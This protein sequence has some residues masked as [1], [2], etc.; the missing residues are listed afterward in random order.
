MLRYI[1]EMIPGMQR[2]GTLY[3]TSELNATFYF[4]QLLTA[5]AKAGLE[6]KTVGLISK[7]SVP[8]A[9]QELCDMDVDAIVQLEDNLT[10]ATFP[11][12][13]KVANE[14]KIP[15]FSFVNE[16]AR[17]GSVMVLS[18]D[19]LRGARSAAAVAARIMKGEK[20]INIPF[21]RISKFDLI[22]NRDA[23]RAAG[24]TIPEYLFAR[25]D[26]VLQAGE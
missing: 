25:A 19:Y 15:V 5:G 26:E 22:I 16:Q 3:A 14:N 18:P 4:G 21:G 24:I 12:I 20:P 2:V 23:A 9:T 11:T 13:I 1:K 6:V 10:S 7:T 17:Q 8:Q